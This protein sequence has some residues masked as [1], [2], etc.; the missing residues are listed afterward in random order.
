MIINNSNKDKANADLSVHDSI[1]ENFIYE[2]ESS[3]LKISFQQY[4]FEAMEYIPSEISFHEVIGLEMTDCNF[5]GMRQGIMDC[6]CF[7]PKDECELIPKLKE[8]FERENSNERLCRL[9]NNDD[10][11]EAEIDFVSG[12]KITIVCKYAVY[13]P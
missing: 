2:E 3:V 7:L 1:F 6:I 4:L 10:F 8:K 12:D 9:Y 11:I 13:N 5:W